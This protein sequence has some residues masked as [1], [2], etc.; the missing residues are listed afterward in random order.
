MGDITYNQYHCVLPF[1]DSD[2]SM[3]W[4]YFIFRFWQEMP[5]L[6][7]DISLTRL[8]VYGVAEVNN[9][10]TDTSVLL[11]CAPLALVL[12]SL[13]RVLSVGWASWAASFVP[14]TLHEGSHWFTIMFYFLI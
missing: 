4:Y 5:V 7:R 6:S 8:V 1:M 2:G 14:H 3:S 12:A 11:G 10:C 9:T 13:L